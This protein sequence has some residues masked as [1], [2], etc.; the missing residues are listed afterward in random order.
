MI[1]ESVLFVFLFLS[2]YYIF[3]VVVKTI[4]RVR[5]FFASCC[6]NLLSTIILDFINVS[7]FYLSCYGIIFLFLYGDQTNFSF[8]QTL[9]LQAVLSFLY[10]SCL[11]LG[12][13]L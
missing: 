5:L 2:N 9:P 7:S 4:I 11:F 12:F 10:P 3:F 13:P 6:S 8:L 1:F